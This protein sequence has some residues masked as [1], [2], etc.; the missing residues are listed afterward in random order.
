MLACWPH[1]RQALWAYPD[2][3]D[4]AGFSLPRTQPAPCRFF[5]PTW[6]VWSPFLAH[7]NAD[8]CSVVLQTSQSAECDASA[9]TRPQE[10]SVQP[11]VSSVTSSQAEP[12]SSSAASP[13]QAT[14]A[15]PQPATS[16]KQ[17]LL[18]QQQNDV[19]P[20]EGLRHRAGARAV[21]ET[22]ARQPAAT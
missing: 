6:S 18:T 14:S 2:A 21:S 15:E 9:A 19:A 7:Q 5:T 3:C 10:P 1:N 11:P 17:S 12:A 8:S 13:V 4:T 16:P 20:A 22:P